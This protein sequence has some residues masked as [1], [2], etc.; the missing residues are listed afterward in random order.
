MLGGLAVAWSLPRP[1]LV[2]YA[3]CLGFSILYSVPPFRLKAVAGADWLI[4]LMGFGLLT[5]YAGW[6]LTGGAVIGPGRTVLIGFAFLFGALYPLTQLYQ[7]DEDRRR[8]DRT[9]ACVLGLDWSLLVALWTALVAF[10]SFVVA[11]VEAQWG[12]GVPGLLRWA[13]LTASALAW[14]AVLAPW[15]RDRRTMKPA[16]HQVGMHRALAAWAITDVAVLYC[17]AR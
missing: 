9:L 15:W 8:G 17:W 14:S 11:G 12:L 13:A 10:G 5:P 6:A 3:L 16:A 2:A 7:L 4:N 1:F